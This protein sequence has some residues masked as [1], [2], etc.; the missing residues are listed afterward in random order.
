MV[1]RFNFEQSRFL[2]FLFHFAFISLDIELDLVGV[3]AH[4]LHLADQFLRY[5]IGDSYLDL[6]RLPF[7]QEPLSIFELSD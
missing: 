5:S 3:Y 4:G 7:L 1:I 6:L 2:G